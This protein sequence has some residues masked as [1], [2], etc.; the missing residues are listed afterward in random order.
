MSIDSPLVELS[1]P[2]RPNTL[3]P[4]QAVSEVV[5]NVRKATWSRVGFAAFVALVSMTVLPIW[6]AAAWLAFMTLWETVL[7]IWLEDRLVLPIARRDEDAGS[8]RLAAIHFFGATVYSTF[9]VLCWSTGEPLGMV[10][11]TAWVCSSANHLFV[12]F[13]AN[14]LLLVACLTPLSA[15]TIAAPLTTAGFDL[16]TGVS[17]ATL[18]CMIVA[19]GLFGIDRHV[20][21]SNLAKV[22]AARTA[23]EQANAA[24]SQFLATMSHELRTPLNAVIGYA[25]LIEEEAEHGTIAE[26]AGKIRSSAR[27]LLGVIDVILDLSKL[28]SGSVA[29]QRERSVVSGVLEELRAAAAPLAAV[30]NNTLTISE[31]MP[32]GDAEIDHMRL[33]QCLM[34]LISNAAKFTKDGAITVTAARITNADG[35]QLM[36]EVADTGI[37]VT[38]DQQARI[39]DAFVQVEADAARKYEGA[40]LGLTL[41]RRLARLMGGDATCESTPGKGS[42]FRLWVAA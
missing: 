9:P 4:R 36:F 24:K 21:L 16:T 23:A 41:V 18:V 26:D 22:A 13:A 11:A 20:L 40:G 6:I 32:L 19:A 2:L 15:M 7:R 8:R 38:P 25:E 17:I 14:R 29:L 42:V 3:P 30:N 31:A 34:Q 12:Y 27:Q 37:G 10:I 28:E 33:H 35:E 39:F 1:T 5:S